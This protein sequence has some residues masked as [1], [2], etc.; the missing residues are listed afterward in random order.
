MSSPTLVALW[1]RARE[2][3]ALTKWAS[4]S[5][6][7]LRHASLAFSITG[8]I[9]R[10]SAYSRAFAISRA[11]QYS[12][13]F[14]SIC[15]ICSNMVVPFVTSFFPIALCVLLNISFIRTECFLQKFYCH[16]VRSEIL[17]CKKK[18]KLLQ[19]RNLS[20][21]DSVLFTMVCLLFSYILVTTR[22]NHAGTSALP[23]LVHSTHA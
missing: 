13:P 5:C 3:V 14:S 7:L 15:L 10:Y 2:T 4:T 20:S 19:L 9:L 22:R 12:T 17:L 23:G 11:V 8:R 16:N 1:P 18:E 21:D 6:P